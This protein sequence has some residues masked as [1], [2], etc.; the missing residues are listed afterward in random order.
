MYCQVCKSQIR[1]ILVSFLIW[2]LFAAPNV[3]HTELSPGTSKTTLD[4]NKQSSSKTEFQA[5]TERRKII[6]FCTFFLFI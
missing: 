5:P 4:P 2:D 6:Y 3:F 1:S